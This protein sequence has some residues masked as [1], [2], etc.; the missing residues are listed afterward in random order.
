M[1]TRAAVATSAFEQPHTD[2]MS[3]HGDGT[4]FRRVA[5]TLDASAGIVAKLPFTA[6][7]VGISTVRTLPIGASIPVLTRVAFLT[8]DGNIAAWIIETTTSTCT[9]SSQPV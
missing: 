8:V 9:H 5:G 1:W 3:S 6:R 7:D 4:W 2:V